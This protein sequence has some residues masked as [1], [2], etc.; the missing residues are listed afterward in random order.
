MRSALAR[1]DVV[2]V[3]LLAAGVLALA[4]SFYAALALFAPPVVPSD[5]APVPSTP[6]PT[7]RATL[8]SDH[9][10]TMLHVDAGVD[11]SAA[12]RPGDRVDI[13][14]YF[15]RQVTGTEGM[16]RPLL[17]N[18]AVMNTGR[19]G[20]RV[21]LTLALQPDD[22]VLLQEA[23]AIGVRPYVALRSAHASASADMRPAPVTDRDLTTRMPSANERSASVRR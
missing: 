12:V 9:V 13:L 22:A 16:T 17:A 2:A 21:S 18:V 7:D 5:N 11:S 4:V 19:D 14:G 6:Q 10:A 20:G 8:P 1:L 3:A 23:Q 15:S